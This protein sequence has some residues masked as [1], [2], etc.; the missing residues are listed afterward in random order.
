MFIPFYFGNDDE[1]SQRVLP[2]TVQV[3]VKG[4]ANYEGN[5]HK[6]ELVMIEEEDKFSFRFM[7]TG[8]YLQNEVLCIPKIIE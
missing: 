4:C 3:E 6:L 5:S 8:L 1:R 7:V 2:H